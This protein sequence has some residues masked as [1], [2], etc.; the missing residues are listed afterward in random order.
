MDVP[1]RLFDV[2]RGINVGMGVQLLGQPIP[3][4]EIN[5]LI[6]RRRRRLL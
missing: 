2:N 6:R 5:D 4:E 3:A 1:G